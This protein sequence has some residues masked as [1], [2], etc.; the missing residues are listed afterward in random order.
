[1]Y[2]KFKVNQD[3]FLNIGFNDF[4]KTSGSS[5]STKYKKI[6]G[7][8]LKEKFRDNKYIDGSKLQEEWFPKVE[9]DVFLSHSHKDLEK[10]KQF[11]GWL[12]NK[13]NL[14]VFIDYNIWG[15]IYDLLRN[16]D[17]TYCYDK[18]KK[19]YS[20][21]KRNLTTSHVH[22]MLLNALADMMDRTE[23]LIFF[24]T[25]NSINLK[26]MTHSPKSLTESPWIYNELFLSKIIQIKQRRANQELLESRASIKMFSDL[27]EDFKPKYTVD[28]SHLIDLSSDDLK[29]WFELYKKP[30]IKAHS[31][32]ILYSLK[33]INV[34]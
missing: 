15:S 12:K 20:Y 19:T 11:A 27:N 34:K 3:S 26:E 32:D 13:F 4:D 14:E 18:I 17:D 25:P 16:I 1:M 23:C 7:D 21:E 31:L 5:L 30:E 8:T 10:A 2:S 22:M 33:N 29:L 24:E 28:L 9:C 6:V